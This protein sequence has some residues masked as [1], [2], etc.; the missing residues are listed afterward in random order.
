MSAEVLRGRCC[1]VAG[2]GP[3]GATAREPWLGDDGEVDDD[4]PRDPGPSTADAEAL[5]AHQ[6]PGGVAAGCRA[7][8]LH[9]WG[10]ADC[11]RPPRAPRCWR[12]T[13]TCSCRSRSSPSPTSTTT[14]WAARSSR[15]CATAS[16]PGPR[17]TW[18]SAC[19]SPR[20]ASTRGRRCSPS[21]WPAAS[22]PSM[23]GQPDV[24]AALQEQADA[25]D[26]Q[27]EHVWQ[28]LELRRRARA[29]LA[30][31]APGDL[32]DTSVFETTDAWGPVARLDVEHA[33]EADPA[34][35]SFPG[36][37]ARA[38]N[39]RPTRAWL[40]EAR[41]ARRRVRGSRGAAACPARGGLHHPAVR[42]PH[43]PRRSRGPVAGQP[44][45]RG[46]AP[47]LRAG[48]PV[49]RRRLDGRSA[50]P[51]RAPRRG[52]P[53]RA[54][55]DHRALRTAGRGGDRHARRTTRPGRPWCR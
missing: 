43:H 44:G 17:R 4:L 15:R 49:R 25:L 53:P 55:G 10:V 34:L 39:V 16:C 54:L 32:L 8:D 3:V 37:L 20:P 30:E 45:Q 19:G 51:R 28:V 24:Y 31:Q 18:R 48:Q 29:I 7:R 11:G 42:G 5:I 2:E 52:Q 40:A 12:R 35:V 33:V 36:L 38:T 21:A 46:A 1:R 27:P 41:G 9:G 26:R 22:S 13:R 14:S 6:R 23:P 50:R 47:R